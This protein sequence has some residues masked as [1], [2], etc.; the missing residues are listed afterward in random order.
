MLESGAGP[1]VREALK[2]PALFSMVIQLSALAFSHEEESLANAI[3]EAI[4]NIVKESGKDLG[5]V[6]DYVS[7]LGTIR[8]CQEQT[9]TFRWAPVFEAV[10]WKLWGADPFPLR[11][12]N[13]D[14]PVL[15]AFIMWTNSLQS[16]PEH[17]MLHL[18]CRNGISTV[19]VWS[20]HI[21]GLT[22][23]VAEDIVQTQFGK[24]RTHMFIE[25]LVDEPGACLM[26]PSASYEPLFNLVNDNQDPPISQDPR[27]E[28]YGY[29]KRIFATMRPQVPD[30]VSYSSDIIERCLNMAWAHRSSSLYDGMERSQTCPSDQDIIE[31][32]Q[33]VL[34]IDNIG[35]QVTKSVRRLPNSEFDEFY[36]TPESSLLVYIIFSLARVHRDDLEKCRAMPMT[37]ETQVLDHQRHYSTAESLATHL[38][39]TACFETICCLLLGHQY[40]L[41]YVTPAVLVSACGWSVFLG[42]IDASDPVDAASMRIR[43]M[44][45]VP[46]RRGLRR[47]RIIDGPASYL[48]DKSI[49]LDPP[50]HN[51][52][53]VHDICTARMRLPMVGFHSD[54]F[55]AVRVFEWN[56]EHGKSC[57][58][59]F[60]FRKMLEMC[61]A[62]AVLAACPHD[63]INNF[64]A[65]LSKS[66]NLRTPKNESDAVDDIC[67]M[68]VFD[69]PPSHFDTDVMMLYG[70]LGTQADDLVFVAHKKCR[71]RMGDVYTV[72][73]YT[74]PSPAARWLQLCTLCSG[75]TP[76]W[77][78]ISIRGDNTCYACALEPSHLEKESKHL[79]NHSLLL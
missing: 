29:G 47:A 32:S 54:A 31:T 1:T 33:F 55:Q 53:N 71:D 50:F 17:R 12:R 51:S 61:M 57:E 63:N 7:L 23:T 62:S 43:I 16:F 10:E 18:R 72:C 60:G 58:A 42:G 2:N 20:H 40:P 35:T 36:E 3:V 66:R 46:S 76:F 4:E 28:A 21:L 67:T 27:C 41:D 19:V 74:T 9:A 13:L 8:V 56:N 70:S 37:T 49:K 11:S 5:M 14:F 75:S 39:L 48:W 68:D 78:Q 26:D 34:A 38:P 25:C 69:A 44:H 30:V 65:W 59:R 24:G 73:Y 6:P 45:G 79:E 22:V 64:K 52:L 15:Q 77:G